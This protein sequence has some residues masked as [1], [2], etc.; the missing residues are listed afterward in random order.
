MSVQVKHVSK[1]E[2]QIIIGWEEI[3]VS[4]FVI[5][6]VWDYLILHFDCHAKKSKFYSWVFIYFR[7]LVSLILQITLLHLIFKKNEFK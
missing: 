4:S 1:K 7:T 5:I 6:F 2:T 3:W